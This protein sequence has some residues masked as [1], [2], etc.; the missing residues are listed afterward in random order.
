MAEEE[1][2]WDSDEEWEEDEEY[3]EM[4][5]FPGGQPQEQEPWVDSDD[6]TEFPMTIEYGDEPKYEDDE[7]MPEC[8]AMDY[9]LKFKITGELDDVNMVQ[10][11]MKKA[12]K[13]PYVGMGQIFE[14]TPRQGGV[15]IPRYLLGYT[16]FVSGEMMGDD[17]FGTFY[18]KLSI[19][20]LMKQN[21]R[22]TKLFREAMVTK[23]FDLLKN[24]FIDKS[25]GSM[26]RKGV[27]ACPEYCKVG[28]ECLQVSAVVCTWPYDAK[29]LEMV[30]KRLPEKG[31]LDVSW[32]EVK[33]NPDLAIK[34]LKTIYLKAKKAAEHGMMF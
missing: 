5:G 2:E 7:F 23:N 18:S 8:A 21:A 33:K 32:E 1:E 34:Y 9:F 19:G 26:E 17:D 25:I 31:Q 24:M 13:T 28:F 11:A 29:K 6:E 15:C 16:C 27:F 14:G 30:K 12:A 20:S 22:P 3:D 4:A 10:Q